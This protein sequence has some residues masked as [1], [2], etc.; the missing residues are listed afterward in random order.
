MPIGRMSAPTRARTPA[1]PGLSTKRGFFSNYTCLSADEIAALPLDD[2]NCAVCTEE[3]T[4]EDGF[5]AA[6]VLHTTAGG[7]Q[8]LC[9]EK[10]MRKWFE[11]K[12]S[13]PTC[14]EELFQVKGVATTAQ[15][16]ALANFGQ[17]SNAVLIER[18][19]ATWG[20]GGLYDEES[21]EESDEEEEEEEEETGNVAPQSDTPLIAVNDED[22]MEIDVDSAGSQ[23]P[24]DDRR[25]DQELLRLINADIRDVGPLNGD[26]ARRG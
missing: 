6:A 21:D 1:E 11:E 19:T 5:H 15:P 17:V 24:R 18:W 14:R 9:C 26:H 13:C 10:C 4:D 16:R 25:Q 20:S 23:Q 2:R 12:N 7:V 22:A 8:H 3:Y